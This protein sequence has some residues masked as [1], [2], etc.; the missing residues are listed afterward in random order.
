MYVL[1][2]HR[3][4]KNVTPQQKKIQHETAENNT[5][6]QKITSIKIK[7]NPKQRINLHDDRDRRLKQGVNEH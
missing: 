2:G 3:S 4:A 1:N 7:N 6:Q 5:I